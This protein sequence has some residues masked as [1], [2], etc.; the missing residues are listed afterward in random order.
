M[1]YVREKVPKDDEARYEL[2]K[3]LL[4]F[5]RF[6]QATIY[7]W[8]IERD[9]ESFLFLIERLDGPEQPCRERYVFYWK[10]KNILC[11]VWQG[12]PPKYRYNDPVRLKK[13][14]IPNEISEET[15]FILNDLSL[16]IQAYKNISSDLVKFDNPVIEVF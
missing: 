7:D 1:R 12:D 2:H 16:A 14:E 13:I 8:A 4:T 15:G 11:D 6:Y 9:K 5:N 10:Y 3:L